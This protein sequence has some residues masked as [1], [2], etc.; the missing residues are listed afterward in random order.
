M[1]RARIMLLPTADAGAFTP[2]PGG[3]NAWI[4]EDGTP[5]LWED[6]T[7]AVWEDGGGDPPSTILG[8]DGSPLLNEDGTE[9]EF[10]G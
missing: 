3:E 8:E 4:W 7:P 1:S 6:G 5:H 9:I 2:S 10:E